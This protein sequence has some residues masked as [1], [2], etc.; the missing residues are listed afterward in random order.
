MKAAVWKLHTQSVA[1][2][3]RAGLL[4][5]FPWKHAQEPS[6]PVFGV[7][8]AFTEASQKRLGPLFTHAF[9]PSQ[10]WCFKSWKSKHA[11][12]QSDSLKGLQLHEREVWEVVRSASICSGPRKRRPALKE[13]LPSNF[14]S[15]GQEVSLRELYRIRPC[16]FQGGLTAPQIPTAQ[17]SV[18]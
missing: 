6:A 9:L 2:S 1:S 4:S 16:F 3:L 5:H 8:T 15:T 11:F 7:R 17:P 10:A 13:G 14:P 18:F 12:R